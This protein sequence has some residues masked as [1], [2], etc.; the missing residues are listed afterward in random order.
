MD[1]GDAR[2]NR[3]SKAT[4]PLRLCQSRMEPPRRAPTSP[5]PTPLAGLAFADAGPRAGAWSR[6]SAAHDRWADRGHVLSGGVAS[7]GAPPV[8]PIGTEWH[9]RYGTVSPKSVI[10]HAP[11]LI[12]TADLLIVNHAPNPHLRA[13]SRTSGDA[14]SGRAHEKDPK[15]DQIGTTLAQ[16]GLARNFFLAGTARSGTWLDGDA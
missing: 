4:V 2:A 12:R 3:T 1:V 9:N 7:H 11:R 8:G 16:A 13:V 14:R 5:S 6:C 15:I 10:L